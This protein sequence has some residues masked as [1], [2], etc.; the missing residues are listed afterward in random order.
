M[1][2]KIEGNRAKLFMTFVYSFMSTF[3]Y[4]NVV[5]RIVDEHPV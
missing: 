4:S 5:L 1:V 3:Y 2:G